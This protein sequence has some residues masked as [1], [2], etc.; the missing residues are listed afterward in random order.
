MCIPDVI[1]QNLSQQVEHINDYG[2]SCKEDDFG[3]WAY[4]FQERVHPD[5]CYMMNP[6]HPKMKSKG[7]KSRY[8][9]Y[10]VFESSLS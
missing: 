8:C 1:I 2:D 3:T 6:A 5:S 10:A 9:L 7:D 4:V